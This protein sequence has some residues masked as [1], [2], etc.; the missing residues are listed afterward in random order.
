MKK[1]SRNTR[2]TIPLSFIAFLTLFGTGCGANETILRSG[3]E[4]LTQTNTANE[5]T[6][7]VKDL[8]AMR[9][10]G[11]TFIYVVR[12]KDNGIIDTEDVGVIRLNTVETNRRVKADNDRAVIIGSNKQVPADNLDVLNDRFLVENY[13][14]TPIVNEKVNVNSNK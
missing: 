10:A 9:T 12:R 1:I 14:D 5:K 3:K 13:S 2:L 8:E 4:T 7:F 6:A 11:F